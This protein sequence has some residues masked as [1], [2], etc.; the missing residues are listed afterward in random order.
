MR[1][2]AGLRWLRRGRVEKPS[3]PLA[4]E[5]VALLILL[6]IYWTF[7]L[8][9]IF[10]IPGLFSFDPWKHLGATLAVLDRGGMIYFFEFYSGPVFL[11]Y[12]SSLWL[13]A[14]SIHQVGGVDLLFLY[15][16][17]GLVARTATALVLYVLAV[18]IVRHR[19]AALVA[20]AF[21][22]I[23]PYIYFRT[24][25]TFPED[26]ALLFILLGVYGMVQSWEAKRPTVLL[27]LAIAAHVY[28]HLRSIFVS[29]ALLAVFLAGGLISRRFTPRHVFW[30]AVTVLLLIAPI[31]LLVI[32]EPTR[33]LTSHFGPDALWAGFVEEGVT[34][35]SRFEPP[36]LSVY[37]NSVGIG[38]I[39]VSVLGAMAA[40][41][42][43]KAMGVLVLFWAG[44]GVV[45]TR[46]QQL[47]IW[48]PVDRMFPY[49]ILPMSL[50]G[51][52]GVAHLLESA[53]RRS[54]DLRPAVAA[55]LSS[56]V[57]FG[58]VTELPNI[59]GW[60]AYPSESIDAVIWLNENVEEGSVI[61]LAGF[62]TLSPYLLDTQKVDFARI[63]YWETVVIERPSEVSSLVSET[64]PGMLVYL[65]TKRSLDLDTE[66]VANFNSQVIV[67]SLSAATP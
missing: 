55:V 6:A 37:V 36:G 5:G 45:L 59:K 15:H 60:A 56:V 2:R 50:L 49:L 28:V 67:Y 62:R 47:Y 27:A 39:A 13:L 40:A 12:P 48:V 53:S 10:R 8:Q 38:L 64:Y 29:F 16:V 17:L 23:S 3:Q 63:S 58:M 1:L 44:L 21:L 46:G 61:A 65:V 24:L 18:A 19:G 25:I 34:Q 57:I 51:A 9:E 7:A 30:F 66:M 41:V 32:Q 14:A 43:R 54:V 52:I 20:P 42:S 22:L 4:L 26:F 33:L 31:V 11:L 35:S